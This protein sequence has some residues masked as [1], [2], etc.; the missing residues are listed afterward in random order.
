[1][2]KAQSIARIAE[3]VEVAEGAKKIPR[4][5]RRD[6]APSSAT[7][8]STQSVGVADTAKPSAPGLL[9]KGTSAL[10]P[11]LAAEAEQASPGRIH[12]DE[13]GKIIPAFRLDRRT[14]ARKRSDLPRLSELLPA[15][16]TDFR[17]V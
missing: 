9:L 16:W 5:P 17:V 15:P 11:V 1:M 6:T 13:N 2:L 7:D 10:G 4:P 8:P 12:R 3:T 14:V